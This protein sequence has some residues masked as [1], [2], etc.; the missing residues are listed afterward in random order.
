MLVSLPTKIRSTA[1]NPSP[2]ASSAATGNGRRGSMQAHE[3]FKRQPRDQMGALLEPP[4]S[5]AMLDSESDG[6]PTATVDRKSYPKSRGATTTSRSS[7]GSIEDHTR[8]SSSRCERSTPTR[9]T[10]RMQGEIRSLDA[11]PQTV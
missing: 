5:F 3:S 4:A 10:K 7:P 11:S 8:C 6:V 1:P 9:R 2:E